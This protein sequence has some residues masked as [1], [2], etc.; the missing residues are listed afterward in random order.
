MSAQTADSQFSF[1]LPRLSYI[2][3]KWE[4]PNLRTPAEGATAA[5][6]RGLAA[7]LSHQV[8]RVIAWRRDNAAMAELASMSDHELMDIGLSRADVP[9][10]FQPAFNADLRRRG[11]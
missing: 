4:E 5:R 1:Q 2:D 8:A 11:N 7:W 6:K 9:R 3:V 10:V